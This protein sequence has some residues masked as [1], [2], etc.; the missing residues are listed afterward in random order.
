MMRDS[1]KLSGLTMIS[2]ILGLLREIT[3]TSLLGTGL[4]AEAFTAAYNTPNLFRKLLA[5]GAMSTALIPT[6][7]GYFAEGNDK[8][9][10]EFLSAT[11]TALI[12]TVG[13]VVAMGMAG[14]AYIAQT[15]AAM[16]TDP[17]IAMD[18][19]ETAFLI[20]LMFPFL[21]MVSIAAFF[22]GILNS[23]GVFVPSGVGPILFNISFLTVPPLI[24]F[25]VPN[26]A[27]AMAIGVLV[28]GVLQAC[29]QL[30]AV[31]KMGAR[32]R[33]I[34]VRRAFL[35][36]GMKRVLMLMAPTLL[37]MAVYEL[38]A[39]VSTGL[40]YGVGAATSI[41]ISLRL[42]ELILGVFVMSI[43]TVLLPELSI[44]ASKH[45]W[46]R[47]NDR[48][49]KSLDAVLLVTLPIAV[50][51]IIQRV[52]IV[53]VLFQTGQF[54]RESVLITAEIFL[55]HML[56]LIFIAANRIIAP[57]FY[58]QK[59]TRSP[60]LAGIAS[61]TVN[62]VL[63][64]SLSFRFQGVGIAAA[65]SIAGLVNTIAL[66]WMLKK[67]NIEGIGTVFSPVLMYSG[68]LLLLSLVSSVPVIF[69]SPI[70]ENLVSTSASR[71]VFAGIPLT[72]TAIVYC[73]TG[74]FLLWITK[75]PIALFLVQAIKK[76]KS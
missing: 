31:I 49:K 16:S 1:S 34:S 32:F 50:F 8:K 30:P 71:L 43:G 20:R 42:Q 76:R 29:V 58:A 14:A 4:L 33:I 45:E 74:V 27:R 26:P 21:A 72:L 2:R 6:M 15:Y 19:I 69:L 52:H 38:N 68:K 23:H 57:A 44:A 3:R 70:L 13:I 73:S 28:G 24:V 10:E 48:L 67:K 39:F 18:T 75:D 59:D 7:Q 55:Y 36:P 12:W 47:F 40:A 61:F 53:A 54:G 63:A 22:Q 35:N 51:A 11:F 41:Q 9:T 46:D 25:W 37:G 64:W 56:G 5:E 65:L 66:V 62:I 17:T 60:T